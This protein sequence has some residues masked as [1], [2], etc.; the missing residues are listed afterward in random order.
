MASPS[1]P[2]TAAPASSRDWILALLPLLPSIILLKPLLLPQ[3]YLYVALGVAGFA[4]TLRLVPHISQYTLRANI[5]GKDLGKKGTNREDVPVY[6]V[7]LC[8]YI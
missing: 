1:S 5:F 3:L 7:Y 4:A 6:V 8:T 2:P